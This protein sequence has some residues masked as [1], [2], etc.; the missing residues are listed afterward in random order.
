MN[1]NPEVHTHFWV[2]I[3]SL[4][5]GNILGDWIARGVKRLRKTESDSNAIHLKVNWP[6]GKLPTD[7][8]LRNIRELLADGF[9]AQVRQEIAKVR[10]EGT[11]GK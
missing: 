3:G 7:N 4:V 5:A 6:K 2:L 8:E 11:G 10:Q 9:L 1:W